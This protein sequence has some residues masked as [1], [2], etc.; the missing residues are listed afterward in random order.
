MSGATVTVPLT[1]PITIGKSEITEV[2][3]REPTAGDIIEATAESELLMLA[4]DG[5]A[6]VPSPTLVG[7]NVL[8]R[9]IVRMG[10]VKGPAELAH[11]K[12]L[13]PD[14]LSALQTKA[15]ELDKALAAEAVKQT[16]AVR[17]RDGEPGGD[18]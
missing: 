12:R 9:Q 7:V 11:L 10:D 13:C 1:K 14:D 18:S 4:P 8:R 2:E 3:L 17:G 5:P 6:L 16:L 15:D